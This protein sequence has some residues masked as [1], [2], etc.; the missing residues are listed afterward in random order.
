MMSRRSG[1]SIRASTS[2]V[3]EFK[4]MYKARARGRG[5]RGWCKFNEEE[6]QGVGGGLFVFVPFS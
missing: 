4:A 3:Y 5:Y 1:C 6:G 2:T